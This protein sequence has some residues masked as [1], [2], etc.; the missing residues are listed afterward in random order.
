MKG[1]GEE[2]QVRCNFS[3]VL[4]TGMQVNPKN[5][6]VHIETIDFSYVLR[7]YDNK[8]LKS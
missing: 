1:C 8:S 7:R 6:T 5:Q 3:N 2:T 4:K